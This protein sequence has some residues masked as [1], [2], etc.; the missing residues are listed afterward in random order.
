MSA[1]YGLAADS[2]V[3]WE[4]VLPNGTIARV[5]VAKQPGLAVAMRGSGSQFG[6]V[7]QFTIQAHPIK[8]VWGGVR[9]YDAKHADKI[10]AAL[11]KYTSSEGMDPKSA[12][13]L[14]DVKAVGG[15]QTFLIFYF[16]DGPT[17]PSEGPF[18][19]FLAIPSLIDITKT[20]SYADLLKSNGASAD[21]LQSR[22]SFR[23][24]TIPFVKSQP[25]MYKEISK[26]WKEVT[27]P[28]LKNPLHATAQCSVDFQ[29]FPAII[30]AQSEKRGGNAMGIT[31]QDP[32]RL[33]LELQCSWS[34][35]SDD[36][37]LYAMSREIT[38]WLETKVPEWLANEADESPYLPFLMNDAMADQNVTGMYKDYGRLKALQEEIDPH[39]MFDTRVG[40]YKY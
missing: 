34:L 23:T 1:Q 11:H 8:Q 5:D 24:F 2:I 19:D 13:I 7:T 39:G 3:G 28:Y 14:T 35:K 27:D 29:P 31:G 22:V 9:I 36:E 20:Q 12:I 32:D 21:L 37:K 33:L 38:D 15:I 26:K 16:Y 10:F 40:G 30:G 18:S 4:T 6:V 17:A 25:T